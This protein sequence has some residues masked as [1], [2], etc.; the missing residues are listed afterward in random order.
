MY[1]R[2]HT[3]LCI[4]TCLTLLRNCVYLCIVYINRH[5]ARERKRVA[6]AHAELERG[7]GVIN[8]WW[9][10]RDGTHP[11]IGVC[12]CV[13]EHTHTHKSLGYT[14]CV[15]TRGAK[16]VGLGRVGA[17]HFCSVRD[18]QN[19]YFAYA[20]F[21]LRD[22]LWDKLRALRIIMMIASG[23]KKGVSFVWGHMKKQTQ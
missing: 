5:R 10:G 8:S 22:V 14:I 16:G 4:H 21:L 23:W 18:I 15:G 13:V 7:A 11:P 17:L 3:T 2:M 12:L 1:S 19:R 6:R 20:F 9:F